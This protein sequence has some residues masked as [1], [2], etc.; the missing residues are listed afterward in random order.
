M[1]KPAALLLCLTLV[2][3]NFKAFAQS[4]LLKNQITAIAK[5]AKG[6][7]G[8]SVLNIES[9]KSFS[10]NGNLHFP[11]Q[12]VMKFPIAI[13][14]LHEIDKGKLRLDQ[15]IHIDNTSP[16][17]Y[18]SPLRDA[19]PE[20]AF[21]VSVKT[22]LSFMVSLSDNDACD[23]LLKTI[24]GP[25]QVN[26]YMHEIGVKNISVKASEFEMAQAWNVQ[27]TNWCTPAAMTEL[28]NLTF[29]AN[30]LSKNSH[31][32]L[33]QIL[34]ETSTGLQQLKGLLP[35]GTVVAHKTGRSGTNKQGITAATN[36]VGV[37][38][39]PNG[40]HLAIAVFI[41]NSSADLATR[42]SVIAR[43]A[44]AAYNDAVN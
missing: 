35:A 3:G 16:K 22:L 40:K 14:V 2:F 4:D 19:H 5:E 31:A 29:R 18:N 11:M 1:L 12:S 43:I 27:F 42:E 25:K 44:K 34:R 13:M 38:T 41:T 28:L 6:T 36:D 30:F 24:G 32:Y 23:I 39:L 37:I 21:D 20:S 10:I 33:W 17:L 26:T 9:Q 7:V 15:N 8:V